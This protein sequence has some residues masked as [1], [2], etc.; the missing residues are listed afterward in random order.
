[1]ANSAWRSPGGEFVY[2][3]P[4][5]K[6]VDMEGRVKSGNITTGWLKLD[7]ETGTETIYLLA[8]K[9]RLHELEKLLDEFYT[10]DEEGKNSATRKISAELARL[11]TE[12]TADATARA[13]PKRAEK[14]VE[15]GA[16][17]RGEDIENKT[18]DY[19]VFGEGVAFK[20]VRIIH[21]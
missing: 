1:M 21:R 6:G 8:S 12:T 11:Q 7:Q 17:F 16:V 2:L 15:S 4:H 5:L 20:V 13:L 14:P 18:L 3:N 19:E 9:E 10:C